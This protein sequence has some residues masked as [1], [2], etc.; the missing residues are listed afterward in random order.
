[1]G[2]APVLV[3]LAIAPIRDAPDLLVARGGSLVAVRGPDGRLE[4]IAADNSSRFELARW[5]DHD[6]DDRRPEDALSSRTF[7]CDWAGCVAR[8]RGE[9]VA[10]SRRPATLAD[11]CRLAT[12]LIVVGQRDAACHP[13]PAAPADDFDGAVLTD[14]AAQPPGPPLSRQPGAA[15]S[16]PAASAATGEPQD[17]TG[18]SRQRPYIL[19]EPVLTREV[20]HELYFRRTGT[21]D[22]RSVA[23][24]RGH[25]PWSTTPARSHAA[26]K[27]ARISGAA[28][29][30]GRNG[31]PGPEAPAWQR[32]DQSR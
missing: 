25:R 4:A 23:E 24:H 3:G 26:E 12:I 8:I 20:A 18:K 10:V 27:S 30:L 7:R 21:I 28:S 2:I 32:E 6:G 15:L 9:V 19:A 1:L 29:S 13:H 11:D 14:P 16:S 31:R 5:L 17:R 22:R